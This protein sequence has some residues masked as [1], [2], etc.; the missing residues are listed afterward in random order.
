MKLYQLLIESRVDYL[1]DK[2]IPLIANKNKEI[3]DSLGV[4]YNPL[5]KEFIEET[6]EQFE[7]IL[8]TDNRKPSPILMYKPDAREPATAGT[9]NMSNRSKNLTSLTFATC[10][11]FL[12]E[13][14]SNT[15]KLVVPIIIRNIVTASIAMLLYTPILS[16]CVEN[17]PVDNAHIA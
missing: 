9:V 6:E 7:T 12:L 2:Y 10:L 15:A 1:K 14:N 13:I 11:N 3:Y 17:P 8:N 5:T 16:Y 4:D